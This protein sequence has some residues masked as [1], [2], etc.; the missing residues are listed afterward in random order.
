MEPLLLAINMKDNTRKNISIV[1]CVLSFIP[2]LWLFV[3]GINSIGAKGFDGLGVIFILPSA[4]A[5]LTIVI[6]FLITTDKFKGGL[7]YSYIIT[8]LRLGIMIIFLQSLSY[9]I[10]LEIKGLMSNLTFDLFII[11]VLI[12]IT[13]PS[14]FNII[15]IKKSYKKE[16][17]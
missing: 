15:K 14:I 11:I 12:V 6:D 17:K 4:I 2:A 7:I 1:C 9:D 5:L 10:R 3:V 8:I 16:R 13:I